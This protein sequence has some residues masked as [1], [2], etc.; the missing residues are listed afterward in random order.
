MRGGMGARPGGALLCPIGIP[1][2]KKPTSPGW[3]N[4]SDSAHHLSPRSAPPR[5]AFASFPVP[6]T[7]PPCP[8]PPPRA[9]APPE[10][11]A[12]MAPNLHLEDALAYIRS[13][14]R[15]TPP[16]RSPPCPQPSAVPS[17][18]ASR[19]APTSRLPRGVPEVPA[20]PRRALR[21]RVPPHTI[22]PRQPARRGEAG[23]TQSGARIL[24]R[25]SG[26]TGT[27]RFSSPRCTPSPAW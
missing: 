1:L 20:P 5:L 22:T 6:L 19:G 9:H 4:R 18:P 24:F 14:G 16:G 3:L 26:A 11:F 23:H 8:R 12:I 10:L 27:L 25:K 13:P 15:S 17:S 21:L 2:G 7:P